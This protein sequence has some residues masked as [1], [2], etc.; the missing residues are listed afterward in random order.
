MNSRL[1]IIALIG[2]V[3]FSCKVTAGK[4]TLN[5]DLIY[6]T[7]FIIQFLEKNRNHFLFYRYHLQNQNA[8]HFLKMLGDVGLLGVDDATKT[9]RIM[10]FT[11]MKK[12]AGVVLQVLMST[13]NLA[14]FMTGNLSPVNRVMS[15][16][17]LLYFIDHCR[18]KY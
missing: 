3:L 15:S 10:Q 11:V 9:W 4:I 1:L 2:G 16:R 12:M 8:L 17:I 7:V 14:T 13:L 18:I 6:N 5:V